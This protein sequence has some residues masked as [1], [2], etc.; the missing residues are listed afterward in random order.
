M[1]DNIIETLSSQ[2]KQSIEPM[3]KVGSLVQAN[4]EKLAELQLQSFRTYTELATRQWKALANARDLEGLKAFGET[5]TEIASEVGKKVMADLKEISEMGMQ[6]KDE[7][8]KIVS[9]KD[10]E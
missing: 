2:L 4:L 5:Q 6:L 8:E 7:I 10:S 3:N 1:T 9:K